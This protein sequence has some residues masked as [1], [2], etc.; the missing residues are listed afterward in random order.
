M[1]TGT[2]ACN[3][4]VNFKHIT[5]TGKSLKNGIAVCVWHLP[6][7][8]KGKTIRGTVTLTVQGVKVTRSFTAKIS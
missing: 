4:T 3:A 5:P 7:T 1:T 2:I 8:A 6:K